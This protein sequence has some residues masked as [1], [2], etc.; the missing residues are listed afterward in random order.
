MCPDWGEV[1]DP[2]RALGMVLL[3][4]PRGCVFICEVSLY[5]L[6]ELK[7]H[8]RKSEGIPAVSWR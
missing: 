8:A 6:D 2:H 1:E 3:Y 4:G 5:A 7:G